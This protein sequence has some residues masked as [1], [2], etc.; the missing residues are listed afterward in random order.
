MSSIPT[1]HKQIPIIAMLQWHR[2]WPA[3]QDSLSQAGW[4]GIKPVAAKAQAR[5]MAAW[6]RPQRQGPARVRR[7]AQE[8]NDLSR[9]SAWTEQGRLLACMPASRVTVCCMLTRS[10]TVPDNRPLSSAGCPPAEVWG[11]SWP[12]GTQ[13]AAAP[14]A[15][16]SCPFQEPQ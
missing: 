12:S 3:S 5:S 8:F 9:Q 1:Y 6:Q 14:S 16:H 11:F 13:A 7:V 2:I 15:L 4:A 10:A